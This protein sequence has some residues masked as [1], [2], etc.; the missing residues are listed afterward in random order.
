VLLLEAKGIELMVCIESLLLYFRNE[1]DNAGEP[2]EL[3]D[4]ENEELEDERREDD[5]VFVLA[6]TETETA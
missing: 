4:D 5:V 3:E 2:N 6:E 1:E